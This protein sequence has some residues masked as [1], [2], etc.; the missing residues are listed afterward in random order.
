MTDESSEKT[1]A[2]E[3]AL[4][5][6]VDLHC[7]SSASFDGKVDP[8]RLVTLARD[9]G[10]TA[11]AI[12][13][14]DTI[15]GALRAKDAGVAG[16]TVIVGQE[17]RTTEGDLILLFLRERI[18][19]GLTPEATVALAHEQGA[20]VGLAHPF[21][22]HRPSIG[23]GVVRQSDLKRLAR[24]ADYVEVYNGRVTEETANGLAADLAREF[25]L[26]RVAVSDAH[27]AAE[28]G[29]AATALPGP[30]ETAKAVREVLGADPVF[31]IRRPKNGHLQPMRAL[32][33]RYRV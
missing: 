7:H 20:L 11:I 2:A 5:T 18:P 1:L 33:A 24:L 28:I 10:L 31:G 25:N 4:P 29:L 19:S 8:V 3:V 6:R 26:P 15:E 17:T 12:T 13:D 32:F 27:T 16:I 22:V 9:R 14:H 30:L 23:R 21:D